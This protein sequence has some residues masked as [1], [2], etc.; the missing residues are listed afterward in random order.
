MLITWNSVQTI[1]QQNANFRVKVFLTYFNRIPECV[2]VIWN[3]YEV[4]LSAQLEQM[5]HWFTLCLFS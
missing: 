4:G 2:S 3:S 5:Q 1:S